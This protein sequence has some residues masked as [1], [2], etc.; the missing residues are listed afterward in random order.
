[1]IPRRLP[2]PISHPWRSRTGLSLIEL[3][4]TL[5]CGAV[6]AATAGITFH[7]EVERQ[8]LTAATRALI[9]DLR[10]ARALAA[11]DGRP[12]RVVLE[13]GAERYRIERLPA[14]GGP[15]ERGGPVR[16]WTQPEWHAQGVD[17]V[18]STGGARIE[19][20]PL[21]LTANWTTITL[22]NRAGVRR[23][24]TVIA[25]GRVKLLP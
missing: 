6:L 9:G 3:L 7:T 13:P 10:Y 17:L 11:A 19:F 5:A 21:G 1:M 4:I 23:R 14:A 12:V 16:D 18:S 15:A 20:S 2:T 24:I 22:A 25:S 8:R